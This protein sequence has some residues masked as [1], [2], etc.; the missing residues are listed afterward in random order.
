[1]GMVCSDSFCSA[2]F[3]VVTG[4]TAIFRILGFDLVLDL[5][6]LTVF[7]ASSKLG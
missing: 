7:Q 5:L 3:L 4:L 6:M 2:W 1:M